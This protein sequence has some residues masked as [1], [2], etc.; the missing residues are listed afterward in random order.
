VDTGTIVPLDDGYPLQTWPAGHVSMAVY[1]R[2]HGRLIYAEPF[3]QR[4]K[5]YTF[6]C[7]EIPRR[8][9]C[10]PVE[11]GDLDDWAAW[12]P[13]DP[14]ELI[15]TQVEAWFGGDCET[16]LLL[17]VEYWPLQEEDCPHATIAYE[18]AIGAEVDVGTCESAD[19]P[20]GVVLD[21]EIRYSNVMSQA[22]GEPPVVIKKRFEVDEWVTPLDEVYPTDQ[23]LTASFRTYVDQ[24]G[25]TSDD[26]DACPDGLLQPSCAGFILTHLDSW[27]A[28]HMGNP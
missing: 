1:L 7:L 17:L 20:D 8:E 16:A 11:L 2:L 9:Y 6:D 5:Q 15:E 10:A 14:E 24:M 22:V 21:C 12:Y 23:A 26:D 25:I 18:Q 28:W 27:A 19:S 4:L 13:G 3:D